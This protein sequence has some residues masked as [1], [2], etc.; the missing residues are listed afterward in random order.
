MAL[1]AGYTLPDI[2]EFSLIEMCLSVGCSW[3][4]VFKLNNH[5]RTQDASFEESLFE[6]DYQ[7]GRVRRPE[8]LTLEAF[9]S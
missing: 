6:I 7:L 8:T 5:Q 9:S 3:I 1:F 4:I 2:L